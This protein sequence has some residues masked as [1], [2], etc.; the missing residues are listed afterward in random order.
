MGD[1]QRALLSPSDQVYVEKARMAARRISSAQAN[2][3]DLRQ[4]AQAVRDVAAFDVEVPTAS[5]HREWELVKVGVKRLSVWYMRYLAQQLNEFGAR[6]ARMG[7]ALA[8]RTEKLERGSEELEARIGAAEERLARLEAL[9][10]V[11]AAH[12]SAGAG[13]GSAP[14]ASPAPPGGPAKKAPAQQRPTPPSRGT[15]NRPRNNRRKGNGA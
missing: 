7:D 11:P 2:P 6:V 5:Q 1:S 12:A 15:A 14:T 8:A 4:V 3:E 13:N 10:F 9:A